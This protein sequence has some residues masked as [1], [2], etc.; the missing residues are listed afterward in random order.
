MWKEKIRKYLTDYR[1]IIALQIL[2]ML[3]L[4]DTIQDVLYLFSG[5]QLTV[6]NV[7][8]AIVA[9]Y[10]L[11]IF[12]YELVQ[13][14]LFFSPI[15]NFLWVFFAFT[16]VG[17]VMRREGTWIRSWIYEYL[18]FLEIYLSF[19]LI[20]RLGKEE[21]DQFL[22][23]ISKWAIIL[24]CTLNTISLLIW[25][26]HMLGFPDLPGILAY[27]TMITTSNHPG[28]YQFFGLYEWVTDGSHRTITTL[29]LGLFLYARKQ[30]KPFWFY[31]NFL[32]AFA[33]LLL[34]G[35]R[36][37]MLSLIPIVLYLLFLGLEKLVSR[38][39]AKRVVLA[40][41]IAGLII[42]V[43]KIAGIFQGI[44]WNPGALYDYFNE[45]SNGRLILWQSG[46]EVGLQKPIFGWGWAYF[47]TE[48]IEKAGSVAGVS[49]HNV[50]I[51]VFVFTGFV[52]VISLLV[53]FVASLVRLWKN[54][55]L[56]ASTNSGWLLVL[57]I[58]GWIQS[59]LQPGIL[60]ENSHIESIYFWIAYGYLLYLGYGAD[61]VKKAAVDA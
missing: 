61:N 47:P 10:A 38:K 25:I 43:V 13:K 31:L 50:I 40:L 27:N 7:F 52:G 17:T 60:G 49:L 34:A 39:I 57:V 3:I 32:T 21:T 19:I 22:Y 11:C 29:V 48:L 46:I 6:W 33:Y 24:F 37:A 15:Q 45:K 16:F 53:F 23:R 18:L 8:S 12:I 1:Y 55:H 58:C 51:N 14:K 9:L 36:S 44:G 5:F 26:L 56:I 4:R 2:G 41:M 28:D 35:A 54:R 20:P 59:M 42:T 30:M